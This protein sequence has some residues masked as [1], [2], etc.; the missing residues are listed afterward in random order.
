MQRRGWGR[1]RLKTASAIVEGQLWIQSA[2]Y[3]PPLVPRDRR[4]GRMLLKVVHTERDLQRREKEAG[5]TWVPRDRAWRA[6]YETAVR[7]GLDDRIVRFV[8]AT[9]SRKSKSVLYL[10]TR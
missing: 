10:V 6:D 8:D 9:D 4:I 1:R 2:R 7:L 3:V 5:G